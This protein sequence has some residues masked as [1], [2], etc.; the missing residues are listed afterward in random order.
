MENYAGTTYF[1]RPPDAA[2]APAIPTP[3]SG[4]TEV[5]LVVEASGGAAV[6]GVVVPAAK[7]I[8][9]LHPLDS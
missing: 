5:D 2:P 1:D 7:S 6:V 3:D 4:G 9:L 8:V